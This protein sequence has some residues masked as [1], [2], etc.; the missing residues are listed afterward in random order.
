MALPGLA[1]GDNQRHSAGDIEMAL[2]KRKR[3]NFSKMKGKDAEKIA[4]ALPEDGKARLVNAAG[5]LIP[6]KSHS[7][8]DPSKNGLAIAVALVAWLD[9]N[10]EE[11]KKWSPR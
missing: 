10:L 6:T 4:D 1:A 9:A 8:Y 7:W 11:N 3:W 5:I 2:K